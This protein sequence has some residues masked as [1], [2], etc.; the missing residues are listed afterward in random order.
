M[1]SVRASLIA[2]LLRNRNLLRLRLKNEKIDWNTQEAIIRFRKDVEEGAKKFG[3]LPNGIEVAP[4]NIDEIYAEWIMPFQAKK[5]KI[6]LYFHGGGYVSGSCNAHRSITAKFV[7][8][9]GIGALLFD[10]RLAPEHPYPAAL[11]DSLKAYQFLLDEG[12]SPSNIIFMGDSGGG[13]LLLAT[14]LALKDQGSQTPSAAVALSPFTDFKLTGESH[15]TKAKVCLSPEG[16]AKA[17]GKHYAGDHDL[18]LPYIS[19]LYGDLHG[20][21]PILIYAGEDETL[22]DD[23]IMFAEKAKKAGVDVTLRV[24]KGLFHCYPAMAPLFP[25]AKHALEHICTFINRHI[26]R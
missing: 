14:L 21:P 7:E 9:S 24:G 1:L 3:K 22:R 17:F 23:S 10:Y 20:L 11:N 19:P 6:I 2:F 18:D 13:G 5:D 25:E 8:G 15:I 16:T 12:V 4:A 26:G